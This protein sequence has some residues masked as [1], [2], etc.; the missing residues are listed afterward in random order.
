MFD[1]LSRLPFEGS[2]GRE[3]LNHLIKRV[4]SGQLSLE[5]LVG[6]IKAF[7]VI[8]SC[9]EKLSPAYGGL[10]GHLFSQLEAN[11]R[12]EVLGGDIRSA[13]LVLLKAIL[14]EPGNLVIWTAGLKEIRMLSL[15]AQEFVIDWVLKNVKDGEESDWPIIFHNLILLAAGRTTSLTKIFEGIDS[16]LE[17]KECRPL[18]DHLIF[19]I[20][21]NA[22]LGKLWIR[23]VLSRR[24]PFK[25]SPLVFSGLLGLSQV[26]AEY[27]NLLS[28]TLSSNVKL[29][30]EIWIELQRVK[31]GELN[32]IVVNPISFLNQVAGLIGNDS[33]FG[34]LGALQ[35]IKDLK[36][37][38]EE[39]MKSFYLELFR[40]HPFARREL[41]KHQFGFKIWK[42]VD[43]IDP[44]ILKEHVNGKGEE[45]LYLISMEAPE[46]LSKLID[47]EDQLE[48]VTLR[49]DFRIKALIEI[50]SIVLPKALKKH[51]GIIEEA[52]LDSSNSNSFDDWKELSIGEISVLKSQIC[53]TNDDRL[54]AKMIEL[55]DLL[56]VPNAI[57]KERRENL[58][59]L[60]V[61]FV[62][63][64]SGGIF[65]EKEAVLMIS[66]LISTSEESAKVKGGSYENV[67]KLF[68]GAK[69]DWNNYGGTLKFVLEK[70]SLVSATFYDFITQIP[71]TAETQILAANAIC[72]F[73]DSAC[74]LNW[75]VGNL[76]G[77]MAGIVVSEPQLRKPLVN[78]LSRTYV[79]TIVGE[80]V[81][82][83]LAKFADVSEP[84]MIKSIVE[85]G[86]K[87]DCID[88]LKAELIKS[89]LMYYGII[90]DDTLTV[91]KNSSVVSKFKNVHLNEK[92][93]MYSL[94]ALL[95]V[96]Q[97]DLEMAHKLL[98]R[99]PD[100]VKRD[101]D[102][103][104]RIWLMDLTG[105]M[106]GLTKGLISGRGAVRLH[107]LLAS[108]Y[109]LCTK[110]IEITRR[111]EESSDSRLSELIQSVAGQLNK[112]I[113]ALI[114][115]QQD[116]IQTVLK[117]ELSLKKASKDTATSKMSSSTQTGKSVTNLVYEMEK[118]EEALLRKVRNGELRCEKIVRSTARDFKIRLEQL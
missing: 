61:E 16:V 73:D 4:R 95:N 39:L 82:I 75:H 60:A 62:A 17:L 97:G 78:L 105:M 77:N 5:D 68:E 48:R 59:D 80:P 34:I 45:I 76:I 8:I 66:K 70:V 49:T 84:G 9:R 10:L 6:G 41:L 110:L 24:G 38:N 54:T 33:E 55:C 29:M 118:F 58:V 57:E 36:G 94:T 50:D 69:V 106:L 89:V 42:Q 35:L 113:Y 63:S 85:F 12:G 40:V 99:V 88:G 91:T 43:E 102:G 51:N 46:I 67:M 14:K 65:K 87:Y 79:K 32:E 56:L 26:D 2:K 71:M 30:N 107:G 15:Q 52:S 11:W 92:S 81:S 104:L 3:Q 13:Q 22:T 44:L 72:R 83:S 115:L 27:F 20:G 101:I 19:L 1:L 37:S 53:K 47:H 28:G 86:I 31:Y 23:W 93:V 116:K 108:F 109:D 117:Q 21:Q 7:E 98:K 111:N 96:V 18:L 90:E 103:F 114:P 74:Q 25:T 64:N 112:Q 100:L